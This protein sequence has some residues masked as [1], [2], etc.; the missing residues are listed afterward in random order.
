MQ[1]P[2]LFQYVACRLCK[3]GLRAVLFCLNFERETQFFERNCFR[4]V[5][6]DAPLRHSRSRLISVMPL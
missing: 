1:L 2:K 6:N 4:S 5:K 3:N